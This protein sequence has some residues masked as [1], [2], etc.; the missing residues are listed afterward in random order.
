[1]TWELELKKQG[2]FK[3]EQ[4]QKLVT[5]SLQRIHDETRRV[6]SKGIKLD[7]D[8]DGTVSNVEIAEVMRFMDGVKEIILFLQKL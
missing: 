2:A 8:N 7:L 6:N 4:V 5:T 1:M 3:P